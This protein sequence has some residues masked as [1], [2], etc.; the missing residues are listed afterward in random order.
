[1]I[2]GMFKELQEHIGDLTQPRCKGIC[3]RG[4]VTL[5][6]KTAVKV[7]QVIYHI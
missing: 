1:M 6:H 2:S 7:V 3:I 5:C 4:K